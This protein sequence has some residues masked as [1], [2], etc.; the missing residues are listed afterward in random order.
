MRQ[1]RLLSNRCH[2]PLVRNCNRKLRAAIRS[3]ADN[4]VCCNHHFQ[5]LANRWAAAGKDPR[6]IR[7]RVALGFCR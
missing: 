3:I 2:G 6:A 4:L 5:A 7:I 1:A